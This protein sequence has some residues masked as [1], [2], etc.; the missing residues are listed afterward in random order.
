MKKA[1]GVLI[2]C[3]ALAVSL[4]LP[5]TSQADGVIKI[6]AMATL[7]G[8][9]A[10]L[11]QDGMRGVK[12]A[13][14]Q[15]N[16]TVAGKK[17]KLYT[18]STDATPD[19]ATRAAR[20]L[21][22][23]DKVDIVI[24]PLSGSEGIAV[25][26]YAHTQPQVTFFNGISAA[27]DTTL[28][29]PAPNFFRF[30]GDGVQFMAG[31]GEYVVQ[32]KGYKKIVTV[33][34]DYSFAYTNV[35]GF[36]LGYCKAGG[37]VVKRFWVPVGNKDYSTIVASIPDDIDA[38][39]VALG[40]SDAVNFLSQYEQ[41]GGDKPMVGGTVTIDQ[42]V[43]SSKGRRKTYMIG[44]PSGSAMADNLDTPSWKKFVAEYKAAFPKGFPSPSV[45]AWGYYV[46]TVACLTAL[47]KVNGDLSNNH[48]AFRE[49]LSKIELQTPSGVVRLDEN[50]QAIADMFIT[51]VAERPDGVLYSKVVKVVPQVNQ[52]LGMDRKEFLALGPVGR[53]NPPCN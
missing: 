20:K 15:W 29:N 27:Q 26:D 3:A 41:A 1:L 8:P 12:L 14:Q 17:I 22:E 5:V 49:T 48:K 47:D 53:N 35:M 50:R 21:V 42:S 52:T 32:V 44:T 28:R 46:S 13:L 30:T 2:I 34:E 36:L 39:F 18:M 7:E 24:G 45:F 37:K 16:Y 11:G 43:L 6:G 40:G 38:I 51:E 33:A 23:Q 25:K 19:S 10:V 4:C 9:F 31:V